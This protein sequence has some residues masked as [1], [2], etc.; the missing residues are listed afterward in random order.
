MK[1]GFILKQNIEALLRA[2]NQTQKDLAHWCRRTEAWLSA[3][4]TKETRGIP[5]KYLDRIA[6]FFGLATYQ[7]FQPGILPLTERRRTTRRLQAD[8]RLSALG[9]QMR[10]SVG[11]LMSTLTAEDVALLL[12]VRSLPT[13]DRQLVEDSIRAL[14]SGRRRGS[15]AARRADLAGPVD[16]SMIAKSLPKNR[17]AG[18]S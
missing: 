4:L 7:L 5:V 17:G 9:A 15:S 14:P 10:E 18:E 8:R 11:Q 16:V 2:R 6:D 1:A 12:R 3:A 13:G